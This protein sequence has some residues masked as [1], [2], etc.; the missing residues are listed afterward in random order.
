MVDPHPEF[1]PATLA[2]PDVLGTLLSKS[3]IRRVTIGHK[4]TISLDL[5]YQQFR[6]IEGR[7]YAPLTELHG[8]DPRVVL[9]AMVLAEK[10]L[11]ELSELIKERSNEIG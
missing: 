10:W 9:T 1:N 3:K 6:L 11:N 5:D 8:A 4:D 7:L 2:L